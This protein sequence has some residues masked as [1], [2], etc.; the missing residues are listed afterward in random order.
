MQPG[1]DKHDP[2]S[3]PQWSEPWSMADA[4][5]GFP[6][7]GADGQSTV[8][9]RD[10]ARGAISDTTNTA[11]VRLPRARFMLGLKLVARREE[12]MNSQ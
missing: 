3:G 9:G 12:V 8:A 5:A 1:I 4:S 2:R 7:A 10:T 6:V 11:S